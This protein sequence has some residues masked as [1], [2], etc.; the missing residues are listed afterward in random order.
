MKTSY[1]FLKMSQVQR[2]WLEIR[3][4]FIRRN[5]RDNRSK[6]KQ[7]NEDSKQEQKTRKQKNHHIFSPL[8]SSFTNFTRFWI[9]TD[10]I[11]K[12]RSWVYRVHFFKETA[13]EIG[14]EQPK[15]KE[16]EIKILFTMEQWDKIENFE[17]FFS[18]SISSLFLTHNPFFRSF[19]I[20]DDPYPP[21]ILSSQNTK[22]KIPKSLNPRFPHY[23][24][25]LIFT[26]IPL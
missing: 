14:N 7:I 21:L 25:G 1:S 3:M 17:G 24:F 2:G 23:I 6:P 20:H 13:P 18:F 5:S 22:Q 4:R 26:I 15:K 11:W 12:N 10:K 16:A 9:H 19:Q 8:S